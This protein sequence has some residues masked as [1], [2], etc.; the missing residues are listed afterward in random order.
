MAIAVG[1][2]THLANTF[3]AG[4]VTTPSITT[5]A[6]GSSFL[7]CLILA[8]GLAP[9]ISDSKSNTYTLVGTTSTSIFGEIIS[10]YLSTNGTGGSGHTASASWTG[11][12]LGDLYL[13]EI[14]GGAT[15]GLLDQISSPQW[16]DDSSSPFTTNAT[17]TLSQANELAVAF[18]AT[19]TN[20]G[21]ETLTWGNGFTQIDADGNSS[22]ATGGTAFLVTSATTPVVASFTSAGAGTT[23]AVSMVATFKAL[24]ATSF[25]L[26]AANGSYVL[27]GEATTLTATASNTLAA[28]FGSYT[29]TGRATTLTPH[30][31]LVAGA[32][33]YA[34]TGE[35]VTLAQGN[36][37]N[38][39]LLAS[40]G[41]YNYTGAPASSDFSF[42]AAFGSYSETGES[43]GLTSGTGATSFFLI[44]NPATYNYIGASSS[45]DF[46]SIVSQ[47][48]YA[49]TGKS[50]TLTEVTSG[51]LVAGAGSF[52]ITGKAATLST[53]TGLFLVASSGIYSLVGE[54]ATLT[55][56]GVPSSFVLACASGLYTLLGASATLTAGA[57]PMPTLCPCTTNYD[58]ITY[59]YQKIGVIDENSSPSNEQAIVALTVLNDYLL[60]EGADGMRLGWFKQYVLQNCAPLKD[61]DIFGVKLLLAEQLAAHY[62]ITIQNPSLLK[63]IDTA[64]TQLV[65]RSIRYSEA[66]FSE[67]P[68]SQ[69]GPWGGPGWI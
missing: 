69:G 12:G 54:A 32:G 2:H 37:P 24:A 15:S 68:R 5:S 29:I 16:N 38:T 43:V 27:S 21:T 7:L 45:S 22:G 53:A 26:S 25:T 44:A 52:A 55:E 51:T 65:K 56:S 33:S 49:L 42:P 23:E 19:G 1:Q 67:F 36:S 13:I 9:T 39:F 46:N 63:S 31:V 66:D 61:E 4:G 57:S 30:L 20:S 14:T 58:I 6:S 17:G 47:G 41:T 64:K 62:G 28:N 60:N 10:M 48:T 50:V 11:S 34:L 59:A 3:L 8:V 35:A 18:T 40:A